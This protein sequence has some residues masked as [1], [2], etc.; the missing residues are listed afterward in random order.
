MAMLDDIR[1]LPA[2]LL[3]TR[4]TG[5]IAAALSAGRKRLVPTEVGNG[6]ILETIGL[7]AGNALLDYLYNEPQFRHLKPLLEQ[8]RLRLD[9]PMVRA[10][11]DAF[12]PALLTPAQADALKALAEVPDPVDE[13]DVRKACWSDDGVWQV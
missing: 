2:E 1:A 5:A 10:T 7:D 6:L 9:S 13:M 12:V 4:D 3:A 11:I 8:G